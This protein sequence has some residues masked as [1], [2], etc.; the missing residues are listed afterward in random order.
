LSSALKVDEFDWQNVLAFQG[1]C[2]MELVSSL[3]YFSFS[4]STCF[5]FSVAVCC[6]SA[7]VLKE[8]IKTT[9]TRR[10]VGPGAQRTADY[11]PALFAVRTVPPWIPFAVV[12]FRNTASQ[13]SVWFYWYVQLLYRTE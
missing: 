12:E 10:A 11:D 7:V 8:L 4:F 9:K 5:S 3:V 2:V 13:L 6:I 1:R